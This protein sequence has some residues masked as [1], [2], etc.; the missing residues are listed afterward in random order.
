M[1]MQIWVSTNSNLLIFS[2]MRNA[3]V[4]IELRSPIASW[5]TKIGIRSN[6]FCLY[7]MPFERLF[8]LH[9][10]LLTWSLCARCFK[11]WMKMANNQ[12]IHGIDSNRG[13]YFANSVLKNRIVK[14]S[15]VLK[16]VHLF[17]ERHL[18]FS[19]FHWTLGLWILWSYHVNSI[20]IHLF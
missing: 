1:Y 16:F 7:V 19:A 9:H 10:S 5:T 18:S 20:L 12:F 6:V 14:L 11:D 17:A 3:E 13:I 2:I 8:V 4:C 15:F